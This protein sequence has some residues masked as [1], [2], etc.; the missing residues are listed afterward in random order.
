MRINRFLKLKWNS[1]FVKLLISFIAM[2]LFLL[3]FNFLSLT[4]FKTNI[5]QEII[6]YNTLGLDKTVDGYEKHFSLIQNDL[7][8]MSFNETLN[9]IAK[10]E[11]AYDYGAVASVLKQIQTMT[12]NTFLYM[13]N[14]LIYMPNHSYAIEKN[15]TSSAADLFVRNFASPAYSKTFWTEQL[16]EKYA[17]RVFPAD[18]FRKIDSIGPE[19][20]LGL[21]F[22]IASKRGTDNNPFLLIALIDG[23][24]MFE[25]FHFSINDSF[26]ILDEAGT[27]LFSKGDAVQADGSMYPER[28]G[29][30][31]RDGQYYFYKKGPYTGFTYVNVIPH[32][33]IASQ[34]SR[35]NALLLSIMAAAVLTG[36]AISVIL[37]YKFNNPIQQMIEGMKRSG[38]PPVIRSG[39]DEWNWINEKMADMA[40]TN[41]EMSSDLTRKTSLLK[42]YG[43]LRGAKSLYPMNAIREL[44]ETDKPYYLLVFQMAF[45]RNY[46][47]L[48]E[49]TQEKAS[50]FIQEFINLNIAEHFTDAVT[51]QTE[52]N[53]ILTL[54][55]G[56][57]HPDK[58]LDV[59]AKLKQVFDRD[60]AYCQLTVAVH[61]EPLQAPGLAAGYEKCRRML[62]ARSMTDDMQIVTEH[63]PY[64]EDPF[65]FLPSAQE[66]E[67]AAQLQAGEAERAAAIVGRLLRQ[68]EHK[69]M[70]A[71]Q[72]TLFGKEIASQLIKALLGHHLDVGALMES[73][74]PYAQI[75]ECRNVGELERVLTDCIE[76]T[77]RLIREKKE[78]YDPVKE[79]V[80]DY[81][82]KHYNEDISL[83]MAAEQ[84]QRSRSYLSTYLKEKT[85]MTFTDYLHDLRIR[86]AKEM[87][88]EKD[89]R[90]NE[91]SEKIGYQNVNSFIRMF[92]K[93]CG[94]TPGEYRRLLIQEGDDAPET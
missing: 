79:F 81:I 60:K 84:L 42:Q 4:F 50:Y 76:E 40:Q 38:N 85:G 62:L 82:E 77:C 13:N 88:G 21:L 48:T 8:L 54:V 75:Q 53:Q 15:G 33:Y 91:I 61:P 64:E 73:H 49:E 43:Y 12:N 83:E 32:A 92:K 68:M 59:L 34:V 36:I 70:N 27:R 25:R 20:D 39:I 55:F 69:E 66:R 31:I 46:R 72:F 18:R 2:I 30:T 87:L 93:I 86:R 80:L 22:P 78:R 63:T 41:R 74:S 6:R 57:S 51:L 14:L 24:K 44:I 16:K 35:L 71:H 19:N 94:V 26:L 89:M 29:H 58:L 47:E 1:L 90:I 56:E 67:L 45:T 52:K 65:L 7:L 37:S 9:A 11:T 10:S 28:E 17:F 23:E 5:Q 3:S